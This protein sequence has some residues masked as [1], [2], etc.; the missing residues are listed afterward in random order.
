MFSPNECE[1]L[2]LAQRSIAK[3]GKI[4]RKKSAYQVRSIINIKN[5]GFWMLYI[6]RH[7]LVVT[8]RKIYKDEIFNYHCEW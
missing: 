1:D 3:W 4:Q 2:I 5:K 7:L 6:V 8:D